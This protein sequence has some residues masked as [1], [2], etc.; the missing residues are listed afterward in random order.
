MRPDE[1]TPVIARHV[2]YQYDC[3]GGYRPGSFTAHLITTIGAADPANRYRL[4]LGFPGYVA[5]VNEIET[6][7][8]GVET[9]QAIA[10]K[11]TEAPDGDS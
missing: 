2:L 4:S 8:G 6:P 3:H 7:G 11:L 5:A 9:L 10:A 1:I